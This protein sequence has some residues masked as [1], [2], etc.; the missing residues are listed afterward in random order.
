MR[1]VVITGLGMV[2]PVGLTV[3]ESW[4]NALLGRSGVGPITRFSP[5]RL[6]VRIAGEVKNFSLE[7]HLLE[8]KERDRVA[9]FIQFALA[10]SHQAIEDSGILN[11]QDKTRIGSSIGVGI[12]ALDEIERTVGILKD[13]G[14]KWVSPF[15]IPYVITNM[16]SG[17]VSQRFGLEGP[18][19]CTTTACTSGTHGIGEA[20]LYIKN[21][22]A[23]AMVCGGSEATLCEVA[24]AGFANMKALSRRN[25][26]PQRASRPFDR[27]RDGFVFSEAAGILVLEE[28]S[29]AQKRGARIYGEVVGYG[30]SSDAHHITSPAPGGSGAIRCMEAALR[31]AGCGIEDVDYINAHGTSTQ[32]N[33]IAES[34]AIHSVFKDRAPKLAVSSTKGVTGHCL[35]AAGGVEAVFLA[36]S[37]SEAMAP[38]TANLEN[39]DP[40]CTLD[41]IPGEARPMKIRVGL[42]NSF[43][44]GGTNGTLVFSRFN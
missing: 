27:D 1:R 37:I 42:S 24:V 35:G 10:A 28:L 4:Q 40:A 19:I 38:P 34:Q 14:P 33:D 11:H 20:F 3:E 16:A 29:H 23:D 36:K 17:M 7:P 39:P 15:F 41:Y 31:S 9:R 32:A 26:D 2:S 18:S 8:P 30:M 12:G 13:K 22:M 6:P 25:D 5:E 44:F 21:S 43:G